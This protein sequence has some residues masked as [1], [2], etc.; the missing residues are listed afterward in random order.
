MVADSHGKNLYKE[1]QSTLH[2]VN[3]T[4]VSKSNAKLKH[5]VRE[6]RTMAKQ[7]ASSDYIVVFA[8]TNDMDRY[9]PYQLTLHQGIEEVLSWSA[10]PT[11]LMLGLPYRY[12]TPS[13]NNRIFGANMKIKDAISRYEGQLKI[14][15]LDV[16]EHLQRRHYTRHGLHLSKRGKKEIACIL[17]N[18][19]AASDSTINRVGYTN[20]PSDALQYE[21]KQS[22]E[23]R[24]GGS[25][26][27]ELR[28][29][30]VPNRTSSPDILH[31]GSEELSSNG[32]LGSSTVIRP[33][34]NAAR[35][36][37]LGMSLS[38]CHAYF[39]LEENNISPLSLSMA[40]WPTIPTN[41]RLVQNYHTKPIPT[42]PSNISFSTT[43]STSISYQN[44]K[45]LRGGDSG[46]APKPIENLGPSPDFTEMA[47]PVQSYAQI[48]GS[49]ANIVHCGE[50]NSVKS[51]SGNYNFLEQLD[52][53]SKVT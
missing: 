14:Q 8:G 30:A 5:V 17:K 23:R 6:G 47:P 42:P 15:F 18:F 26:V 16:N 12:D 9:E 40:E 32:D 34:R 29:R 21:D 10:K 20:L 22:R 43:S 35:N 13:L 46:R 45:S 27:S 53:R 3:I 37:T 49:E 36:H 24:R 44:P 4:V 52:L 41:S 38:F 51:P 7:L 1:L 11:I 39:D 48:S 2:D 25:D 33:S 50:A 19:V 28:K 31:L